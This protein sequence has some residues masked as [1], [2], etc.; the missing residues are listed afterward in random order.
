MEIGKINDLNYGN[1]LVI[2]VPRYGNTILEIT[3][4]SDID[5]WNRTNIAGPFSSRINSISANK[6][7]DVWSLITLH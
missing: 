3:S 4:L 7:M 6:N 1:A 5:K 2:D